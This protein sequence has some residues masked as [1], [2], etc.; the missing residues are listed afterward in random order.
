MTRVAVPD[1]VRAGL[2]T[3][4]GLCTIF[5][6]GRAHATNVLQFPENGTEPMG[7]GGA[8]V[9]RASNPLATFYNPAGLA[10]QATGVLGNLHLVFNK[11][12]FQ[13]SGPGSLLEVGPA[14]IPYEEVCNEN[15]APT[16]LPAI[17]GVFRATERLGI[18]LS[19]APPAIYGKL[20]FPETQTRTNSFGADVELPNGGRYMLLESDGLALNTTLGAGFEVMPGLRVGASFI[21][22]FARYELGSAVE[23]IK[24]AAQPDGTYLDPLNDVRADIDVSDMFIPG[25]VIGALYSPIEVL[26][27][28]FSLRMQQGF[29]G[30]G[31][32]KLQANYWTENGIS[33]NPTVTNSSDTEADLA[34]FRLPNPMEVRLGARFH[35]PRHATTPTKPGGKVRDPLADDL[36]DVEL[37][38]AYTRNSEYDAARL[39]FP[40][41]PL[42]PVAGT[43]G[44]V[45]NNGDQEFNVT[46]DTLGVRLGGDVVVLPS[47][48]AVRAGGWYE[49]DVQND[50]YANLAFLASQ[51]IGL[52]LGA[53]YRLGPVDIEASY[54]HVF[55]DDVD[56]DGNGKALALSGDASAPAFRSPYATN[57][58]KFSQSVNIVS[59][60]GTAR[61]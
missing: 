57:G 56:N 6:A 14:R 35:V 43:P 4:L 48:L 11:V 16:P 61:F 55:F 1:G 2:A 58:G 34:H 38:F 18:G 28:G 37:D 13:R 29:D 53:V 54:M 21:W 25:F 26:D 22:G 52:S 32:L 41:S 33:P 30:H 42:I 24:P 9:A 15:K 40:D 20:K 5:G 31:D 49:P 45:P 47:Q 23:S 8:W 10:G 7:R 51:R 36:F 27:V 46:G 17:A 39:R 44:R 59:V 60:G 50:E 3:A 12:C 19:I